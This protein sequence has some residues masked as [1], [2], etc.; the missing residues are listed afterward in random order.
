MQKLIS[1][2]SICIYLLISGTQRPELQKNNAPEGPSWTR[3]TTWTVYTV[4]D[5]QKRTTRFETGVIVFL[6]LPSII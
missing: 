5:A 6:Q 3:N 2:I 1:D 4:Q